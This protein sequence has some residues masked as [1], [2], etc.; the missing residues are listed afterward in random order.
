MLLDSSLRRWIG[1]NSTGKRSSRSAPRK[2][3]RTMAAPERLHIERLE[4]RILMAA[5]PLSFIAAPNVAQDITLGLVD[6]AGVPTIQITDTATSTLIVEKAQANTSQVNITLSNRADRITIKND[7]TSIVPVTLDGRNGVDTLV[8]PSTGATFTIT[9][10]NAGTGAG[11][12]FTNISSV[13]GANNA[14]NRF[15]VNAGATLSAGIDG[16]TGG[17]NSVVG[18]STVPT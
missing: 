2:V 12:T 16:G 8:G 13:Q 14:A 5:D 7:F 4:S 18:P 11:V 17:L 1:R 15:V 10:A 6:K 3:S 9:G